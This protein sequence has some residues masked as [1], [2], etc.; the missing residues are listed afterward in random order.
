MQPIHV[1]RQEAKAIRSE[2]YIAWHA[3]RLDG[4][5]LL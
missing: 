4:L 2:D 3:L 5:F 1:E